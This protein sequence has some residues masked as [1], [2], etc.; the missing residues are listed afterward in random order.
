MCFGVVYLKGR[1]SKDQTAPDFTKLVNRPVFQVD[2]P[3]RWSTGGLLP[4]LV[5]G[6]PPGWSSGSH[7]SLFVFLCCLESLA[8]EKVQEKFTIFG[9]KCPPGTSIHVFDAR[10]II[11]RQEQGVSFLSTL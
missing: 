11:T 2:R 7:C 3:P 5:V 8:L 10:L 4:L 9:S 1:T 6:S